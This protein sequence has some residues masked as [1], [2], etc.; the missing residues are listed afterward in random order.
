MRVSAILLL[1]SSAIAIAILLSD[2]FF[3]FE[4]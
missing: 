3:I 2:I 1:D 4:N